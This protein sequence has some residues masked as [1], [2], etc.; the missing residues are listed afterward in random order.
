MSLEN[1]D[2]IHLIL[3]LILAEWEKF[4]DISSYKVLFPKLRHGL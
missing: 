1:R 4:R 2:E 3:H